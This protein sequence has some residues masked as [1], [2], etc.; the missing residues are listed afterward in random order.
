MTSLLTLLSYAL[1]VLQYLDNLLALLPHSNA[2]VHGT[3][4][5]IEP[6]EVAKEVGVI[7][8]VVDASLGPV[9]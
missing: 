5:V 1:V 7:P 8:R 9:L 6:I 3:L 4:V 2:P